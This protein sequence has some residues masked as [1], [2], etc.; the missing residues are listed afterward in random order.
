MSGTE[1]LTVVLAG[2]SG[3]LGTHLATDLAARGHHPVILTRRIDPSSPFEQVVW[4]GRTQG[5][6]A[7]ALTADRPTAVVNLAGKLVDCR[8]SAENIAALR[9]SRV[10]ATRALVTA[11]RE[12][13]TPISYWLQSSTTAIWSDAGELW[14]TESTPTPVGLPQM[15]G[16]ARPWEE[17]VD[18]ANTDHLT[19]L[20]TSIV[21]DAD[22]PAIRRL[23]GLTRFGLGG[24]VGDGRQWFSWIHID[25]WLAIARAAL[26][27]DEGV[28]LPDGVV[29]AASQHPVRNSELMAMLRAEIG[30][31]PAPPTPAWL[32][33]LGAVVLRTDPALGLT[34]RRARSDVLADAG[35]EFSFPR[36]EDA[37]SDLL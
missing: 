30:R 17:A 12:R 22:S 1:P 36:L 26:R 33:K 5:N 29:V 34:G 18:G 15:T 37:L 14:C 16:V 19:V 21:L 31:P 27:V 32:L 20:R 24:R 35:F 6:W 7:E 9:D 4:D 8:P 25:D 3:S 10:D 11:S 28:T 23:V 2:G 13:T